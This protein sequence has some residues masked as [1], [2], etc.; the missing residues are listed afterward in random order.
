LL[1]PGG[2]EE[3]HVV[4]LVKEV[5]LRE[6]GDLG[7]LDRALKGEVEVVHRLGLGEPSRRHT[8]ASAVVFARGNLL[9][10]NG[11]EVGLVIP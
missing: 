5:E 10:E 8:V 9:G 4:G 7:A 11:R 6:V 3:A 1:V 2:P